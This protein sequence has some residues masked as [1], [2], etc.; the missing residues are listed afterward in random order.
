M[1]S[2]NNAGA[3]FGYC[4][5][6]TPFVHGV[7]QRQGR[8]FSLAAPN[9]VA[10]LAAKLQDGADPHLPTGPLH[11]VVWLV[12]DHSAPALTAKLTDVC[13]VLPLPAWCAALRR[14][15]ANNETMTQPP[16]AQVPRWQTDEPLCWDPLRQHIRLTA[17][18][19]A[20]QASAGNSSAPIN[21]RAK[22]AVLAA[23]RS[24]RIAELDAELASKPSLAGKLWRWHGY[25]EPASLAA[26]LL[27]SDHPGKSSGLVLRLTS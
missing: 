8:Q 17:A 11:A 21:T 23:Q 3:D 10:T 1:N 20:L 14:L 26:Q 5:T 18:K 24:A 9:A 15:S 2:I 6:V 16:A 27:D 19:E 25:G 4:L 7:G 22:L 13:T 12:S